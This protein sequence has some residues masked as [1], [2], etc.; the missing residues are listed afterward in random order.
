LQKD[1]AH[2]R[3]TH[4]PI[5]IPNA[6]TECCYYLRAAVFNATKARQANVAAKRSEPKVGNQERDVHL[7]YRKDLPGVENRYQVREVIGA[8]KAMTKS[9][10]ERY[11]K[12]FMVKSS[13]NTGAAKIP[14]VLTFA[15]AVKL[16]REE[17]APEMLRASTFSTAD[18]HLKK[19]LE[20]D[21]NDVPVEHITI[22]AVNEWSRKKRKQGL[23]WVTV[24][25]IL[26]T[27]QRVLSA[28][29]KDRKPPFSLKGLVIPERD[30]LQVRINSRNA[31]SFS[32][33]QTSQIAAQ[34][35]KLDA[36]AAPEK[37]RYETLFILAAASGLRCG[38]L[39]ALR[40]NDIDF[41]AGT[42]RIDE[43]VC[44]RTSKLGLCKNASA[45]RTVL[46]ADE[47]GQ[48]AMRKLKAFVKDH[49][50]ALVFPSR[51]NTPLRES[52][53]LRGALHP[54]LKALGLPQ[55]GMHAFRHGCN[56]RWELAGMNPA[57]LRQQMGH[58]SHEMTARY[59]G[60]IPI[61][62]VRK[63]IGHLIVTSCD[64]AH[65]EAVA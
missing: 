51:L 10:A 46:L 24:K 13:I 34:V 4:C 35:H 6:T 32:W 11:I 41:K 14:S 29:S 27:M 5:F 65:F 40:L 36:L 56:R 12:E 26:R 7:R 20:A 57:V 62:Q 49:P 44:A 33:E 64:Q 53:V 19:H 52:N 22:D 39:F 59:T 21:W 63:A 30:K 2:G 25:N 58:S 47:V 43:A 61:E 50:N 3:A 18:Y 48:V 45:H 28:S 38:E 55:A 37:V 42:I 54:A 9:E 23:S 16:Y 17:F 15:R 31:V 1:C 8:V 60:E